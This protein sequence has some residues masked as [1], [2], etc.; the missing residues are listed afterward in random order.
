MVGG[1][2]VVDDVHS[3]LERIKVFTEKVRS[4]AWTGFS[5]KAITDIVNI[6]IGIYFIYLIN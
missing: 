4:G 5:G 6:G 1:K 2:N 3:V